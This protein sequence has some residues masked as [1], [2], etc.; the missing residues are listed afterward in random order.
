MANYI[1]IDEIK[2]ARNALAEATANTLAT[3][4]TLR[5]S[6][7]RKREMKLRAAKQQE[8][9]ITLNNWIAEVE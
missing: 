7:R 4:E 8:Q 3:I 1:P 5:L 9:L 6:F 2:A